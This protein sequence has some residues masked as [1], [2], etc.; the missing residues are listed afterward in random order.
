MTPSIAVLILGVLGGIN[1]VPGRDTL[2]EGTPDQQVSITPK[3]GGST[4]K[5]LCSACLASF[6]DWCVSRAPA[7][8]RPG[9]A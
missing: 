9:A 1:L 8:D 2:Q 5:Q 7:H 4:Q 6:N 3:H